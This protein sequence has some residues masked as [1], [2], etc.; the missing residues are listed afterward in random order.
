MGAY[1]NRDRELYN[2][3]L[4]VLRWDA[5][6]SSSFHLRWGRGAV[7]S[8][9][10]W[11][12]GGRG[13]ESHRLHQIEMLL[14]A[15]RLYREGRGLESHRLHQSKKHFTTE[16]TES[17]EKSKAEKKFRRLTE[18]ILGLSPCLLPCLLASVFF[19]SFA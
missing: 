15:S 2:A 17:T 13:F 8:A 1:C 3:A 5:R 6:V 4:T 14:S 19:A 10:R 16:G 11:H 18:P 7:G 12:R 9:P